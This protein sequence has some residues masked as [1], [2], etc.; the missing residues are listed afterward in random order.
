M[1]T[2]DTKYGALKGCIHIGRYPGGGVESVLVVEP[3]TLDT[4]FGPL[5]PQYKT[6]DLRRPRHEAMFFH[7]DGTLKNIALQDKVYVETPSGTLPTELMTFYE[8]GSLRRLLTL[9]GKMGGFY[10][11]KDEKKL[12]E[13]MTY[14]TPLGTYTSRLMGVFF[15]Q[16]GD[17][18]SLTFWPEDSLVMPTPAGETAVRIGIAF[19][20]DGS[21]RS[22]E[23]EEPIIVETPIGRIK[24]FDPDAEGIHGD[25]NSLVFDHSGVVTA[26]STSSDRIDVH[27]NGDVYSF[28]PPEKENICGDPFVKD[29]AP[30]PIVFRGGKVRFGEDPVDAFD[31]EKCSFNIAHDVLGGKKIFLPCAED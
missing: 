12:A 14:Q 15:Y 18:R 31:I 26:L 9:N 5:V 10:S 20:D 3:N 22:F 29:A 25:V 6:D 7:P 8:D 21:V 27:C 24:A 28:L 30:M 2:I 17:V 23:P 4:P 1:E 13:D 16:S 11:W 19:H